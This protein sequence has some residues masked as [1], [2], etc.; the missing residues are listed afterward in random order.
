[1]SN[2]AAPGAENARQLVTLQDQSDFQS[3]QQ[4]FQDTS[5]SLTNDHQAY[6][7]ENQPVNETEFQSVCG[8]LPKFDVT[9]QTVDS[10]QN[11]MCT[12][13]SDAGN[14]LVDQV[15]VGM[16]TN[17]DVK[18]IV[19][20]LAVLIKDLNIENSA[21]LPRMPQ[22]VLSG[23]AASQA[24]DRSNNR[25]SQNTP[26]IE[27]TRFEE[28]AKHVID[29]IGK[30]QQ[31]TLDDLAKAMQDTSIVGQ[32]AQALAAMYKN[33]DLLKNL[34]GHRSHETIDFSDLDA[35]KKMQPIHDKESQFVGTLNDWS[36]HYLEKFNDSRWGMTHD[37]LRK[38]MNDTQTSADDRQHL[39]FIDKHW[40]EMAPAYRD[41]VLPRDV[42][43]FTQ[44][45]FE[46]ENTNPVAQVELICRIV[47]ERAQQAG[48]CHDLYAGDP[49]KSIVQGGV[50]QGT[51]ND[52]YFSATVEA[53]SQTDPAKIQKMITENNNGTYTVEFPG[54]LPWE[55]PITVTGPSEA[56]MGLYNGG[57]T[58][59]C[60]ASVLE[61]AYGQYLEDHTF[62]GP[63]TPEQG[64]D[65]DGYSP[66]VM[67]LLTGH[68]PE[69]KVPL[70][71][72]ASELSRTLHEALE[73]KPPRA[74][75]GLVPKD[76]LGDTET[77]P[78]GLCHRNHFYAI[79]GIF[80]DSKDGVEKV[81]LG[82]P[83][84]LDPTG[85]PNNKDN[86]A[87]FYVPLANL[88]DNF[89]YISIEGRK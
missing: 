14:S 60:W 5:P 43:A 25:V 31:V 23:G 44:K 3:R 79:L 20:S 80:T 42:Q 13:N 89:Q 75:T 7:S 50:A 39:Q 81:W 26:P 77:T 46:A 6:Q 49:L 78:D 51:I 47:S 24:T 48:V 33:F 11:N 18:P 10:P 69:V 58:S 67:A 36:K 59:G 76:L 29:K 21:G 84:N 68:F 19:E 34:S 27:P 62:H 85:K 66:M 2:H 56:E 64:A 12:K 86:G 73:S 82:N 40:S 57:S 70:M 4:R 87:I 71:M 72:K 55:K 30:N 53:I 83:W 63:K 8:I 38:A 54:K 28:V 1:V 52:C 41:T 32:D 9:G 35:Y 16:L 17:V 22:D 15:L 45:F 74:V 88:K 37:D 61:K 65:G